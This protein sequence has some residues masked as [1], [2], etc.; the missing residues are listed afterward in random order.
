MGFYF[1]PKEPHS[2]IPHPCLTAGMTPKISAAGVFYDIHDPFLVGLLHFHSREPANM[3]ADI[4]RAQPLCTGFMSKTTTK[5]KK[6]RNKRTSNLKPRTHPIWTGVRL[7]WLKSER[8]SGRT[9]HKQTVFRVELWAIEHWCS[10][11]EAEN[12]REPANLS[13]DTSLMK[14]TGTCKQISWLWL[15][16]GFPQKCP[17]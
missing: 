5:N 8:F 11:W 2:I 15:R 17:H 4:V 10:V 9:A 7:E 14:S 12:L 13:A 6:Q 1:R 16:F 3:S